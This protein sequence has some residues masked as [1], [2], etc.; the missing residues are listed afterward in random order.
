[1]RTHNRLPTSIALAAFTVVTGVLALAVALA[2]A[3]PGDDPFAK[4]YGRAGGPVGADAISAISRSAST[5]APAPE[6]MQRF[7]RAGT[8]IGV[9]AIEAISHS[10]LVPYPLESNAFDGWYGRAGGPVGAVSVP[11]YD[12]DAAR[13]TAE[14]QKRDNVWVLFGP[15]VSSVATGGC[16][17]AGTWV[18]D[19]AGLRCWAPGETSAQRSTQPE[20]TEAKAAPAA[21]APEL[22]HEQTPAEIVPMPAAA[23]LS[24]QV[25]EPVPPRTEAPLHATLDG[26]THFGFDQYR[27]TPGGQTKLDQLVANLAQERF[28]AVVITGHTDRMG[29][30]AYNES[31]SERR[32]LSVK[33]YLT[34]RGVD[35][36]KMQTHGPGEADPVTLPGA[37]E[38]L[39]RT[40]TIRCLAPDRRVELEVIG[41]RQR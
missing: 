7:G 9:D 5:P 8:P 26:K 38:S 23:K 40:M 35:A 32:A 21:P 34:E 25:V 13:S 14:E 17:R 20:M 28:D 29:G 15:S 18:S 33:Q 10:T 37:C 2:S 41:A 24:E 27:L 22:A 16:V 12:H 36:K 1:M 39:D 19:A 31:L 4:S 3:A 30:K 6:Q 11:A